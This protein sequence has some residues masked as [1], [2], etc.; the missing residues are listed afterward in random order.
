M[1]SDR[2]D[3]I[4]RVWH[5]VLA[6]PEPEREAA[7]A[8][9]CA[10]DEA[11]RHDV[12]SLF[13]H[14]ARASAAG[15]GAA[16]A[17]RHTS[18]V[19][20]QIGPYS[21]HALLG[22]GGMGEVYQARDTTL[23]REVAIKIVPD[24]WLASPERRARFDREAWL[25]ASLNHPNVGAI[26]GVHESDGIRALVLE[27]VDGETLA[28][29][30]ARHATASQPR[31][32][33]PVAEVRQLAGQIAEAIEAAHERGI[34][35]RDLKPSNIKVTTDGRVK[36]LDFG[37]ARA[38][39]AGGSGAD[40]GT[41][42]TTPADATIEGALMGTPAYM[43]P[44][45]ARGRAVDVRAD[46]WG[47]GCV[48][49]EMLTGAQVFTGEGLADVLANV[50]KAEPDWSALPADTPAALRVC[51]R[52][53]LQKDVRQRFHHMG[54]VRL[55][56]EGAFE[57]APAGGDR[58]RSKPVVYVAWAA[59][60]LL[61]IAAIVVAAVWNRGPASSAQ[62]LAT[63]PPVL[64]NPRIGGGGTATAATIQ[65]AID[66]V[67][68]GGIVTLLPGTY[69]ESLTINKGVTIQ[70]TGERSGVVVL[71][72][73]GT[74]ESV[75]EIATTE[76]VAL[77][78]LTIHVP[79]AN[80]IR[81]T[82]AVNLTVDRSTVL[83]LNPPMGRSQLITVTH[84]PTTTGPR[85]RAV[86]R[87]SVL[88]GTIQKL[89]P[90]VARPQNIAI[91]LVGDVDGVIE[92]NTIRRT[93]GICVLVTSGTDLAGV[94]NVDIVDNEIDECHPVDRVGAILV[95]VPSVL[96]I[97][98]DQAITATGLVNIVGNTFR[99]S[100][101]DCV[102]AAVAF[103]TFGGRIERNR[104]LNFVQPCANP[105]TRSLPAAVWLGLQRNFRVPKVAP[106][107]RFNDFV[108][109]AQAGIRVAPWYAVRVDASCNF[110]GSERGPSGAGPGDGDVVLVG[111]GA[112]PPVFLPFAKA[113]I[114]RTKV[115]GC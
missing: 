66:L 103:D 113:P 71:A 52:R 73:S 78:G 46:V 50:I 61:G 58:T 63:A 38:V 17:T 88:D 93:G 14:L 59:T 29:R 112:T 7:I 72:P 20:R 12:E 97:H 43:S 80:G 23:G 36:V 28:E 90:R 62:P 99:N 104:F 8:E 10:G 27:L 1:A 98:R 115:A 49:Y 91:R 37:L 40:L 6:R 75:V 111:Q 44:E 32:G 41:A 9:L 65:E 74:P 39:D 45:Q 30:I 51:L 57:A 56:M 108:G 18:L 100:S 64:F 70:A 76:H 92:R 87:S 69:A 25:L 33:L 81:G 101:E 77:I 19:G 114:A 60:A 55:T 3:A 94:T 96:A 26:Y 42:P 34:I 89:P 53:C 82:G 84:D 13:R 4:D 67:A 21:V 2:W 86:I 15:F 24:A 5:A 16:T 47:F 79:G 107:V 48:L 11:L 102:T 35:H 68:P 95:G 110:W 54:D 22:A 31:R 83:A 109:N 105:N 85:A 106:T